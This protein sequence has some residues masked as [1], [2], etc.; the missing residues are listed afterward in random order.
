MVFS[1]TG[2]PPISLA[3]PYKTQILI[4]TTLDHA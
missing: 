3:Q 1:S 4:M 2:L